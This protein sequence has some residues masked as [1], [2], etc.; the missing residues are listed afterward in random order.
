MPDR[1]RG[2]NGRSPRANP[3]DQAAGLRRLFA[4]PESQWLP[5]LLASGRETGDTRW[6]ARF[7]GAWAEQG[8]RTLVVDAARAQLGA[9]FGLRIRYDLAHA[10]EGDCRPAQV[11][12]QAGENLRVL[13]AS[14][15]LAHDGRASDAAQRFQAGVRALAAGA[16]CTLLVLPA[17][18][19]P[20]LAGFSGSQGSS[21]VIT[22]V[23]ADP[24][25]YQR[26]MQTIRAASSAAEIDTFRLL[27]QGMDPPCA[28][29]LYLRL[30]AAAAREL[31][32]RTSDAGHADDAGAI[33][34]LV[35]A[36]RCRGIHISQRVPG[37]KR[38][39]AV[40]TVS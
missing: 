38:V 37:E 9:A 40:E 17:P 6:L 29:R 8:A 3:Q 22:L 12:L 13:T 32:A 15:A 14:R 4:P 26:A 16:D 36:V 33:S 21:D 24:D 28:G 27:F 18:H 23:D 1:A 35:R 31:G 30:A 34:R 39:T 11:C 2:P 19:R 7:A 10:L 20:V 25:A 5:I